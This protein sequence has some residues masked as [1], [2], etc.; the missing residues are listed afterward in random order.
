MRGGRPCSLEELLAREADSHGEQGARLGDV[1]G[2]WR[3]EEEQPW[4]GD[5]WHIGGEERGRDSMVASSH[6]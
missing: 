1:G 6:G 5:N 4:E 3:A 2:R